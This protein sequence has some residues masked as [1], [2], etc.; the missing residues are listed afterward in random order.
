[1]ERN[2]N[3]VDVN[4]DMIKDIMAGDIPVFGKGNPAKSVTDRTVSNTAGAET[5]AD[6]S[7]PVTH[8]RIPA[9]SKKRKDDSNDYRTSYLSPGNVMQRQQTYISRD[10]YQFLKRFLP[11]VAPEVSISR[12]VDNILSL[13][14][15]QYKEEIDRLYNNEITNPL[16]DK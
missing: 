10:N 15:E 4:E 12:Y 7:V 3:K 14:L 1:M 8:E 6:R 5:K 13:H 16:Y 2:R 9:R 11:V